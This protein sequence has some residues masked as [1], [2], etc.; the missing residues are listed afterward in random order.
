MKLKLERPLVIKISA[1][2]VV[3]VFAVFGAYYTT[4]NSSK[5]SS[6]KFGL[7]FSREQEEK[8][9]LDEDKNPTKGFYEAAKTET[10]QELKEKAPDY[11]QSPNIAIAEDF[12]EFTKE[13]PNETL[14]NVLVDFSNNILSSD[15]VSITQGDHVTWLNNGNKVIEIVGEDGWGSGKIEVDS[16]FTQ[17]FNYLGEY[18]FTVEDANG[19]VLDEGF[20]MVS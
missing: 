2:V 4:V 9:L 12:E 17:G 1:V 15:T 10:Y 5:F 18:K 11:V 6:S 7:P 20:V 16:G 13:I 19:N 8:P 14:E 3:F